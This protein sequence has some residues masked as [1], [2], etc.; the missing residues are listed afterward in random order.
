MYGFEPDI[1]CLSVGPLSRKVV[2]IP[3]VHKYRLG[4]NE[5]FAPDRDSGVSPQFCPI[6]GPGTAGPVVLRRAQA[7]LPGKADAG[8]VRWRSGCFYFWCSG[9]MRDCVVSG[10]GPRGLWLLGQ[11]ALSHSVSRRNPTHCTQPATLGCY[12]SSTLHPCPSVLTSRFYTHVAN[13]VCKW[14]SMSIGG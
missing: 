9:L 13:E 3:V 10:R 6:T 11:P 1:S 2:W 5:L 4:G 12:K 8:L 14:E 7:R